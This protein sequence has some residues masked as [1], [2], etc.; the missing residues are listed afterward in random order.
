M[1]QF[2]MTGEEQFGRFTS[3]L[4]SRLSALFSGPSMYSFAVSDIAKSKARKILDV[5][6]GPAAIPIMLASIP[7]RLRIYAVDPSNYMLKIAS[8]R[9]Q[10]SG[11][12]FGVGYSLYIPFHTKFDMII[13]SISFHHWAHKKK[14][15]IYL[16]GFLKKGGEIRIYEFKKIRHLIIQEQHSMTRVQLREAAEGTGL[17]VKGIIEME[18]KLRASYTKA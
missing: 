17:K 14:S 11:I 8:K 6:T 13:S 16:S 5:G 10:G 1:K 4:Y 15:L 9:A 7:K 2:D 3:F 18:G 12:R